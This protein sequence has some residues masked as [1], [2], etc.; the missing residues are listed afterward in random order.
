MG[1]MEEF[2]K[3]IEEY[4]KQIYNFTDKADEAYNTINML[5]STK[6][7]YDLT[8]EEVIRYLDSM[9]KINNILTQELLNTTKILN[10][11]T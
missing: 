1:T 9:I 5:I 10:N 2:K 11:L 8:R 4:T 6:N 7:I 3:S